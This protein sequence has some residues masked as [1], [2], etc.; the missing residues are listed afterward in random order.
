MAPNIQ[1]NFVWY[2]LQVLNWKINLIG[3]E[4]QSHFL[5]EFHIYLL[6]PKNQDIHIIL[7]IYLIEI[8]AS[9]LILI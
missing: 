6:I 7:I 2:M 4:D 9:L 1:I 5:K 8:I 3:M